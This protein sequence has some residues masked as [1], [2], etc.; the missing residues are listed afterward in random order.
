MK[1]VE[2]IKEPIY[3]EMELF[4]EKFF[5]SMSSKVALLNRITHFIVNR[6]GKQMRPMFVFLVA[7]MPLSKQG[8][9]IAFLLQDFGQRYFIGVESH[10]LVRI[11]QNLIRTVTSTIQPIGPIQGRRVFAGKDTC[12]GRRTD[13]AGRIAASKSNSF[14]RE[15]IDV[16]RVIERTAEAAHVGPAQVIDKKEYDVRLAR[17]GK[18]NP[19]QQSN[20]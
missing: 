17:F 14:F 16:R 20:Q 3:N 12:S 6:K 9:R 1:I 5:K 2:N 13:M 18:R 19:E 4:E 8:G 7:K 10:G 15:S 11:L